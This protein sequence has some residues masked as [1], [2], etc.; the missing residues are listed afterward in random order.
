MHSLS[1]C[2]AETQNVSRCHQTPIKSEAN[3][4]KHNKLLISLDGNDLAGT[5][6]SELGLLTSLFLLSFYENRVSG[7]RSVVEVR[8]AE[9]QKR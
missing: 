5:I 8:H 1:V 3:A 7:T 4:M 2:K 9:D 6:P